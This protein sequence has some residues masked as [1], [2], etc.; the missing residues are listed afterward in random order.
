[1]PDLESALK[2]LCP[3]GVEYKTIGEI[4]TDI[5]R[6]SGIKREEILEAGMPCVRYG[7]IY[8]TYGI[9]FDRCVSYTSLDY[10]T[11][12]KYF[13]HGD[14]LFAITGESVE[15]IAKSCAYVGHERCIAGGDI[16]V[17]K[18]E[19]NPKYLAYALS[20][21]EAKRQKSK[22]KTKNKVVHSSVPSIKSIRIPIPP[23]DIQEDLVKLLDEMSALST[24]LS[25]ELLSELQGRKKQCN[26]YRCKLLDRYA[27]GNKV[28][29]GELGKWQGGKTPSMKEKKFWENGTIPWISSKDMKKAI[30][31]DTKDHITDIALKEASMMLF[32]EESIAIVTRSGILKHT[33]PV[34]YIPF[35][36]TINQDIKALVVRDGVSARYVSLVMQ[37]YGEDIRIKTKKQGGT[38]DS[39]DFN[40]IMEYEIPLPEYDEQLKIVDEMGK[41]ENS[42]SELDNC[43]K[44]E[45]EAIGKQ[46]EYYRDKLLTFKEA[47]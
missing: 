14:I 24:S 34:A 20:T 22:G 41:L 40:K 7:E 16:V 35:R 17:L 8:T 47:V 18:H 12:P 19:Q 23:L 44:A 13:E 2:R 28:R 46:Y 43:L 38:V 25:T 15:D 6:G 1:M 31:D 27:D 42:F 9:W 10:V 26:Y 4:A 30:L 32:P 21:T 36:T 37:A 33:F 45:I 39:L 11:S 29:I 3:A 5:Y